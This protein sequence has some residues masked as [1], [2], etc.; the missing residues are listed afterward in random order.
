MNISLAVTQSLQQNYTGMYNI[1]TMNLTITVFCEDNF[2]GS[3]CTQCV[4]A[5]FIGPD[6]NGIDYCYC[7]G[8]GECR[9][10]TIH[11]TC[12]PGFTG[13][14]CQTNIDECIGVT[15]SGNGVC[16]DG[17]DTFTCSC[18]QG[19]TGEFCQANTDDCVGVNCNGNGVCVDDISSFSCNC[20]PGFTGELCQTNIDDCAGVNCSG[21]SQCVDGVNDFTCQ[22]IP[23]F[24]GPKCSEGRLTHIVY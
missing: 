10:D 4:P 5:G 15:C 20:D 2:E 8:N 17:V 16:V 23:G 1:V 24:S 13:E 11:C 9:M 19:F 6:C 7:S 14:L 3:D 18:V 21:N 22:C 12:D